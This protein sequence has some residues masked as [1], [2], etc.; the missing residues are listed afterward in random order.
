MFFIWNFHISR[1]TFSAVD[2]LKFSN[3]VYLPSF[4]DPGQMKPIYEVLAYVSLERFFYQSI[5]QKRFILFT[6]F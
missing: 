2:I 4:L 1:V 5:A 3:P 6:Y